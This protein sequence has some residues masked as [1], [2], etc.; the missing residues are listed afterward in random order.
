MDESLIAMAISNNDLPPHLRDRVIDR[1]P[2]R[3]IVLEIPRDHEPAPPI[4]TPPMSDPPE[5]PFLRR[6]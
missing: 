5:T 2:V 4:E 1:L 6:D 3:E